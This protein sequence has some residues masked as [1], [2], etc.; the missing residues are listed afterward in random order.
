MAH[1]CGVLRMAGEVFI[2]YAREDEKFV[3]RLHNALLERG[4]ETWVDW[5]DIPL[6]ADWWAEIQRGIEAA[7]TF[8]FIISPDSAQSPVCYKE[9]DYA[10]EHHKR[11]VPIVYRTLSS[12]EADKLHPAINAHNWIFM[13]DDDTFDRAFDALITAMDTDLSFVR[14]HTALLIRA[15]AWEERQRDPGLLLRGQALEDAEAWLAEG[16]QKTHNRPTELHEEYI[17]RSRR[18]QNRRTQRNWIVTGVVTIIAVLLVASLV[19]YR[20]AEIERQEANEQRQIAEENRVIAQAIGVSAR[21]QLELFGTYPERGVLLALEALEEFPYVFQA[22]RALVT[23][24]QTSRVRA[25]FDITD[26]TASA[27]AWSPDETMFVTVGENNTAQLW[28]VETA[29]PL[30]ITL[31]GHTDAITSIDWARGGRCIVTGGRDNTARVW[32]AASGEL[33]DTFAGHNDWVL[34]V[35]VTRDC[36]RLATATAD[37]KVRIW[38]V[39]R[40][41][42]PMTITIQDFTYI[43]S[44]EWSPDETLLLTAEQGGVVRIW[45]AQRGTQ[46]AN[47]T[48]HEDNVAEAVW[49]PDGSQI[50][51]AGWDET[52][53]IWNAD[54]F[55]SASRA[56]V[57]GVSPGTPPTMTISEHVN[58]LTG[59]AWSPNGA[60]LLTTSRD[61]TSMVWDARTG[62]A[63]YT[64]SGHTAAVNDAAWSP[65]GTQILTI[66]DD[67][68]VRLWESVP[69]N[70]LLTLGA[71]SRLVYDV[72]WS[73]DGSQIVTTG[74]DQ[75]ALVWNVGELPPAPQQTAVLPYTRQGQVPAEPEAYDHERITLVLT[76]HDSVIFSAAW[77]PDG[78]YIAT[79]SRDGTV[80]IWDAVTGD[81]L[82]L[83]AGHEGAV[84]AVD[85]SPDGTRIASG[86]DENRVLIW[87]PFVDYDDTY[88]TVLILEGH[89]RPVSDVDWS[90]DGALLISASEDGTAQVWNIVT[91][92]PVTAIALDEGRVNA[93]AFAPLMDVTRVVIASSEGAASVWTLDSAADGTLTPNLD[94][95]LSGHLLA[96]TGVDWSP[97]G[98]RVVTVSADRTAL[99]WDAQT[100]VE[101][102]ALEGHGD[103]VLAVDWSPERDRIAT[104]S[105]DTTAKTWRAFE[106]TAALK[107]Y[108]E[109]CCAVRPLTPSEREQFNLPA[110]PSIP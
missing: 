4:R 23:A 52:A 104:A 31:I 7:N 6:T 21:A 68:R 110:E 9:I 33:V 51:T 74:G 29:M 64:L 78:A 34:D 46:L 56:S 13:R 79:G 49:S 87:E 25:I 99:I 12:E 36:S 97:N 72:V 41:G 63:L 65:D 95:T 37:G 35:D 92:Q 32:D 44:V 80:R 82:Y 100:G 61:R 2:S 16:L 91:G 101:L 94:L 84:K 39:D 57:Q 40:R 18:A 83:F 102:Y 88:N 10:A 14:E 75:V 96:V 5:E 11:M 73:P 43:N 98:A 30:D 106:S 48:A 70:T 28:D 58:R 15:R 85:W 86:D 47:W 109:L 38:S 22:E 89:T 20:Q 17:T 59:V 107:E 1:D 103:D 27:V 55:L 76:G 108:A 81:P 60:F 50:A 3:R 19:L 69:Q 42:Q 105:Q 54:D 77:S 62:V 71:H 53:H 93:A 90:P 24:V 66:A 67:L 45:E 8:V 26:T